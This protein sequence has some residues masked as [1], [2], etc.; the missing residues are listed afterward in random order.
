MELTRQVE[1]IRVDASALADAA[2]R[3]LTA[4]IP[5]CPDW[6]MADLVRHIFQVHRS[7]SRIV[8]EGLMEPD[9]SDEP[10]PADHTLVAEF[11]AQASQFADVL[12]DTDPAKPCWTWGPEENAG[13]VQ[14]FQVQEVALHRWD[15]ERAVGAPSPIATDGAADAI[16]LVSR[17]VPAASK[18]AAAAFEVIATDVPLEVTMSAGPDLP[19]AGALCGPASDLL[20]VGWKRLPIES[21]QVTGDAGAIA[22]AI[23]AIN[24]D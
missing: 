6:T 4:P 7:W 14:R 13:F 15:A 18:G 10:Y 24:I 23:D 3:D 1:L 19:V 21:V 12:G 22:A 8:D 20:L 9:W 17:L 11:R 5:T 16:E 2:D